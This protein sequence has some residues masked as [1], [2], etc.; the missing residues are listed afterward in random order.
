MTIEQ[1]IYD[2]PALSKCDAE[3]LGDQILDLM[4]EM[5]QHDHD[6]PL[7]CFLDWAI[8]LANV[9]QQ[10]VKH[11]HDRV[12]DHVDRNDVFNELR[13]HDLLDR[14]ECGP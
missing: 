7:R 3:R 12:A 13:D 8:V 4:I 6:L 10:I 5:L 1:A 2:I 9:R 11:I 14:E